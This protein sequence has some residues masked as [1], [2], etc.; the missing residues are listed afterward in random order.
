MIALQHTASSGTPYEAEAGDDRSYPSSTEWPLGTKAA[1]RRNCSLETSAQSE[2]ASSV[3]NL[4]AC[5]QESDS[6]HARNHSEKLRLHDERNRL[7]MYETMFLHESSTA[8]QEER[9]FAES[10]LRTLFLE[11]L[12]NRP[13]RT[14]DQPAAP[15]SVSLTRALSQPSQADDYADPSAEHEGM[16]GETEEEGPIKSQRIQSEYN[17]APN[18]RGFTELTKNRNGD[19][20]RAIWL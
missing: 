5:M 12:E 14:A 8:L 6:L 15:S 10:N 9:A 13:E 11:S 4:T 1:T 3:R 16:L 20:E 17:N 19:S 2:V 7:R 18:F